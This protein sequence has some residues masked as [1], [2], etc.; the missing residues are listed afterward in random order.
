MLA[1]SSRRTSIE[2]IVFAFVAAIIAWPLLS[3]LLLLAET[4][5]G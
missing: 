3:L 2:M 4:V 1:G 5:P